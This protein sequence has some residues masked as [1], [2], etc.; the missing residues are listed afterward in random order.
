VSEGRPEAPT[1]EL[2]FTLVADAGFPT[3]LTEEDL[4]SLAQRV[5]EAEGAAGCWEVTVARVGDE[6]LQALHRDFLGSDTQ[7]DIMTF[8]S[9]VAG[10]ACR[11]GELAISVDHA[12][13]QA[14]AWGM[15]PAD[16]IRFLVVHG[17]LHL[18][19][20]RD[21]SGEERNRMLARQQ[22]LLDSWQRGS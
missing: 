10:E 6:R 21:D 20:W 7:T 2:A 12:R 9:D 19:G 11:G 13:T 5:L 22:E 18:L 15:S 1:P 3:E 4:G 16:E 17:L 14:G 8:P